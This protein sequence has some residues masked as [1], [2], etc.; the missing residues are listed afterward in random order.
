MITVRNEFETIPV[1]EHIA[2]SPLGSWTNREITAELIQ[3][4]GK[5]TSVDV[6]GYWKDLAECDDDSDWIRKMQDAIADE[7]TQ[8]APL[9]PY[10]TVSL[11][12]NE[13]RVRPYIDDSLDR[14]DQL[15]DEYTEDELLLIN[16]HG[17]TSLYTW[18][19]ATAE[20]DEQWA[21]V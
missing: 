14:V 9:P 6:C 2:G 8:N 21:M 7:I 5:T 13:W 11:E 3:V 16:D 17:N 19:P 10:C 1:F 12:D 20:Y 18:N 4:L 15:P